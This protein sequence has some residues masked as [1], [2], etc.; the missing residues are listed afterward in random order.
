MQI[1]FKVEELRKMPAKLKELKN[2]PAKFKALNRKSQVII[3]LIG[4]VLIIG[5]ISVIKN[6]GDEPVVNPVMISVVQKGDVKKVITATGTASLSQVMPLSFEAGGTIQEIYV[7]EGEVVE[8]G[9]PLVRLDTTTLEQELKEATENLAS[10]QAG[11]EQTLGDQERRLKSNLVSAEKSLL[12]A[13]QKADPFYLEN[14]Y[15]LAE[16][17]FKAAGEKLA[18]AQSSGESDTYQ[19]QIALSQAQLD[20]IEAKNRRDG[21]A[22]KELEVAQEEYDAALKAKQDFENGVSSD[23]LTARAQLTQSETRFLEA[24]ENL[25]NAILEAPM[26]GTI[27][28]S[29][30]ELYQNVSEESK[31]ISL[32]S[33]PKDFTVKA[34]V[35]QTEIA[36]IKV[37][38]KVE[39]TLDTIP[40]KVIVGTVS[41]V[42]LTGTNSQNVIT[43][44]VKIDVDE[45][46]DLL[47][48]QMN[49]NVLIT[50]KEV[51]DVLTIPSQALTMQGNATGVMV[52]DSKVDLSQGPTALEDIES[53]F[54]P[55]EL[56][57]DDGKNAEVRDGLNEGQMIIIQQ[58][59]FAGGFSQNNMSAGPSGFGGS[60]RP[61]GV[62]RMR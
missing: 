47:R 18:T 5:G 59:T 25:S 48:D 55:I 15:Y 28:S 10:A 12:T 13:Q 2:V 21:G 26:A 6:L 41:S 34:S 1:K 58:N 62:V 52:T 51:K 50:T 22:V 17:N 11:Y 23:Y 45:P 56:G 49:V 19:L 9:Q 27:I 57:L 40:D 32:V 14:Q 39:L 3:S 4:I 33:D 36:D 61:G 20:L 44:S 54:V 37:G 46:S 60:V 29:E 35:D 53:R 24:Q 16:L 8:E 31:V 43:Y 30:V 38:Q 7:N 42:S